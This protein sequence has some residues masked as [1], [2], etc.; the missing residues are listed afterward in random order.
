MPMLAVL[1]VLAAG[2]WDEE[3]IVPL[4]IFACIVGVAGVVAWFATDERGLAG[5]FW[6]GPALLLPAVFVCALILHASCGPGEC[7]PDLWRILPFYGACAAAVLWH[8]ALIASGR[9][10]DRV[11]YLLYA[12]VFL[13]CL[14][15][16]SLFAMMLAN[17]PL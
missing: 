14:Y 8:V 6:T 7:H 1:F 2:S 11:L 4:A 5:L 17:F 9:G 12:V 13:P 3:D 10:R 16:Y 15:L